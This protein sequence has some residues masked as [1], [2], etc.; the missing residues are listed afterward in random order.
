MTNLEFRL[1]MF[2]DN[3]LKSMKLVRE[4][5]KHKI[6]KSAINVKAKPLT[7]VDEKSIVTDVDSKGY[8]KE[9]RHRKIGMR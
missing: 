9:I 5:P 6:I 2:C 1:N 3:I 7:F 8:Q 4:Y